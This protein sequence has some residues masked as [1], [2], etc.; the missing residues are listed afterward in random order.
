MAASANGNK[1]SL[2]ESLRNTSAAS[3]L[4]NLQ[5]QLKQKEGEIFQL[6]AS[7]SQICWL[8]RVRSPSNINIDEEF[9][10]LPL[11]TSTSANF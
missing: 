3:L 4:E 7:L 9:P 10:S 5:S 1:P 6:Q 11:P 8:I 2:Y